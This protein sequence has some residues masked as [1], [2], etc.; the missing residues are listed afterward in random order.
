MEKLS[1]EQVKELLGKKGLC[2]SVEEAEMIWNFLYMLAT[3]ALEQ[4]LHKPGKP[5][6]R[7]SRDSPAKMDSN[8]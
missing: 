6:V 3:I 2:V 8:D 4:C 5:A 1:P 7:N